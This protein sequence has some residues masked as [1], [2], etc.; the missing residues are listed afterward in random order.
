MSIRAWRLKPDLVE[1]EQHRPC[2]E[3]NTL[4]A[5]IQRQRMLQL[6]AP[7]DPRDTF[8]VPGEKAGEYAPTTATPRLSCCSGPGETAGAARPGALPCSPAYPLSGGGNCCSAAR[9]ARISLPSGH[10]WSG[11]GSNWT[12]LKAQGTRGPHNTPLSMVAM[13]C[14]SLVRMANAAVRKPSP[15]NSGSGAVTSSSRI[16][17]DRPIRYVIC[18]SRTRIVH[19]ILRHRG[20]SAFSTWCELRFV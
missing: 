1:A 10:V 8:S 17:C 16:D 18:R 6:V 15:S 2:R 13:K 9:R 12:R 3:N 19:Q 20:T 11:T 4:R 7:T 14:D 5:I